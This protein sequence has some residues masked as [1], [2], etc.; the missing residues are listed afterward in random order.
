MADDLR[1][2]IQ[3]ELEKQLS[4]KNINSDLVSLQKKLNN[5]KLNVE[6]DTDDLSKINSQIQK[7]SSNIKPVDIKLN[8]NDSTIS[9]KNFDFSNYGSIAG[10][11]FANNF[12][13][14]N[15]LIFDTSNISILKKQLTDFALELADVQKMSLQ[16]VTV[17][18]N[19][20]GAFKSANVEF[21]NDTL[22]QTVVQTYK[23]DN[24]EKEL[25]QSQRSLYLSN[26]KT[27][28][29]LK[30]Q[31][32]DIQTTL[33]KVQEFN[34]A[35]SKTNYGAF[36]S[37]KSLK[38]QK[39]IDEV[40]KKYIEVEKTLNDLKNTN[41]KLSDEQ[42]RGYKQ[43]KSEL[44]ALINK[45]KELENAES[46]TKSIDS[47]ISKRKE[48]TEEM[49]LY[50]I[51]AEK[52][53]ISLNSGNQDRFND[54]SK[55]ASTTSDLEEMRHLIKLTKYE[56][57]Q[58][59]A[60]ISK[61]IPNT[62]I[63]NMKKNITSMP[64][65]IRN[66]ESNLMRLQNPSDE[67]VT[68][69]GQLS[70]SFDELEKIT[71]SDKKAQSY[72][73]LKDEISNV[74]KEVNSLTKAQSQS[75]SSFDKSKFNNTMTTWLNDNSKAASKFGYK[76]RE[77]QSAL[78]DVDN[79]TEF[80][81]LKK[82]FQSITKEAK[83][84][85]LSGRTWQDEFKNNLRKFSSWFGISQIVMTGVNA[86]KST[87]KDMVNNV[88]DLDK[89]MISLKK[90]SEESDAT[91]DNFLKDAASNAKDLGT[92]LSDIVEM[93]ATW[94]KLGYNLEDSKELANV[95]TIY[96]NVGEFDNTEKAVSDL[97]TVM[98]AYNIE[99][100][101]A[102]E[103]T[104]KLNEIGNKYATEAADLGEGISNAAS[105]L[106][107][108]GNTLDESL[109]MLTAGT[110]ITQNAS[111][112]GNALKI[113]SMR[114]RGMKGKLQELGEESEDILPVSKIQTQILNLTKG[115]VNIFDNLDPTKFKSTYDI[116]LQI[117]KVWKDMNET[118]KSDL[119]EIIAGKQ[120]GN[121]IAALLTNMKQAE[122]VLQTS[123]KS[124][125]SSLQEQEEYMKGIEYSADRLKAS[126]QE[127]SSDTISSDFV[128]GVMDLGNGLI[129]IVDEFVEK[130]GVIPS[131]L[132]TIATGASLFKNFGRVKLIS[133]PSI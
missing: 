63:D 3:A 29:S 117:S 45:Y 102:I 79:K 4:T 91:Y 20:V 115:K 103:I 80:N 126:F 18:T 109:A 106:H 60:V 6:L 83:A 21:Y 90:V 66:I 35:L 23:L 92:N 118:E 46:N 129:N 39:H 67:L 7:I 100:D 132:T 59:D 26:V 127:L 72:S 25:E 52:A 88:K 95:S 77:I 24:S 111:E 110:E 15:K 40:R 108:A 62:A 27:S 57:R 84:L 65:D 73:K 107:I 58:L 133:L 8:I 97:V 16:G 13:K 68:R 94:K 85:N 49:K 114:L 31:S 37:P 75:I 70:V 38:N 98:K 69:I 113:L 131:I 123:L 50:N 122:N 12:N 28:E 51:Q 32:K 19:N 112:M 101:N 78:Q 105:S 42:I 5:V 71:D 96:S 86:L 120:R 64:A 76:I 43:Q 48:L 41:G 47:I 74:R 54:L 130:A 124:S 82:E 36:E 10:K 14:H 33:N 55:N 87:T 119:L 53:G 34:V 128:K 93:T 104:D 61:D 11:Q 22:K 121:D 116:M 56:Y 30:Q 9:N 44:D 99:A 17:N 125:G 1:V 81:N 2:Q 89:A